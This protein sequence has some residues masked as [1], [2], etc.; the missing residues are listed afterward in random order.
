MTASSV[1]DGC[2]QSFDRIPWDQHAALLEE[3]AAIVQG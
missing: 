3:I 2:H 1:N